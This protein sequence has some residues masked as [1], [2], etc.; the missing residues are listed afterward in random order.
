M[1]RFMAFGWRLIL[2]Y[3][4]TCGLRVTT[5]R[6]AGCSSASGASTR[7]RTESI[8]STAVRVFRVP[9]HNRDIG[10]LAAKH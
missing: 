10:Q 8:V 6:L 2:K 4:E 7:I 1:Y 5:H 9:G 3:D